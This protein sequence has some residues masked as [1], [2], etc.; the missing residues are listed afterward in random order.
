[1]DPIPSKH[2]SR[3]GIQE[4]EGFSR[5]EAVPASVPSN[6]SEMGSSRDRPV[7]IQS[8]ASI[9]TILQLENRSRLPSSRCLP[10]GLGKVL[11]LRFP[12]VLPHHK[13]SGASG[14]ARSRTNDSNHPSMAI[15]TLVPISN[16]QGST[17]TNAIT[18]SS[19]A[20]IEPTKQNPSFI[21]KL[22]SK[23]SGLASVGD[24]LSKEGFSERTR[25]LIF[26]ARREGTTKNYESSW[27]KWVLWCRGRGVDP[28]TCPV[29]DV[30]DYL[31]SLYDE[32][33]EYRTI[34]VQR[35]AISAYHEPIVHEGAMTTVGKHPYISQVMSGIHNLRPPRPKHSFTWDVEKVLSMFKSWPTILTAKPQPY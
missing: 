29:T 15:S 22:L 5:M 12:S 24:K 33:F 30:T 26:N 19:K 20:P 1:M 25:N 3:L 28:L 23:T 17:S 2:N 35:S 16:G 10:S 8:I 21:G 27:N 31:A 6:L 4:R 7:R 11:P 18:T 9:K 13:S 34:G 32:G 14:K